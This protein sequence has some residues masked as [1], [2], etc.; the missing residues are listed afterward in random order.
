MAQRSSSGWPSAL[1]AT[2]EQAT[3]AYLLARDAIRCAKDAPGVVFARR[4]P[5]PALERPPAPPR[6]SGARP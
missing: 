6:G 3:R 5:R 1:P 2:H 4:D